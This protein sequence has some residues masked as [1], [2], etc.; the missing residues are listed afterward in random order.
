MS[1][2][3]ANNVNLVISDQLDWSATKERLLL[4]QEKLN[5]CCKY[6][7]NRQLYDEYPRTRDRRTMINIV[8][9]HRPV[10]EGEQFLQRVT[11][12][13]EQEG[14]SLCWSVNQDEGDR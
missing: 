4:L 6:V 14:F 8:F 12:V 9:F 1:V 2:D 3:D 13:L 7:E 10:A 11:S 5:T